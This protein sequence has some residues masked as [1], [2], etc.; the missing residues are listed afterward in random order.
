[1][2]C[3]PE[4]P[5]PNLLLFVADTLRADALRCYG[6]AA[7]TPNICGLAERGVLFTAAQANAP[8]TSPSAVSL[9][10]GSYPTAYAN[11]ASAGGGVS[12]FWVSDEE[13]LLGDALRARG[14]DVRFG[15]S[16]PLVAQTNALQGF[17]PLPEPTRPVDP[18]L[19]GIGKAGRYLRAHDGTPFFLLEWVM[20][21]HAPYEARGVLERIEVDRSR[22]PRPLEF[23]TRL[24]HQLPLSMR[25]YAPGMSDYELEV[26]RRL[27]RAEVE[28]IDAKFGNLARALDAA[29]LRESTYV[30]FTSDHGEGFGEHGT[31]LHGVSFHDELTRVPLIVAG[32]GIAP[33]RRVDAPVSLVDLMPTLRDLLGVDCLREPQGRSLADRL[34]GERAGAPEGH[35]HY[36]SSPTDLSRGI[37]ALVEG[38]YKLIAKLDGSVELYDLGDDPGERRDLA[39]QRSAVVSRMRAELAAIRSEKDARRRRNFARQT[40]AERLEVEARTRSGLRELGYIE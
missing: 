27:Y 25:D 5:R 26:L 4:A 34:R 8:W 14:Y 19:A 33:G 21:A 20:D 32:P 17:E 31:F 18:A 24:G 9:F 38:E 36:L 10:T 7:E 35:A 37:D 30:V 6:G 13:V 29:G 23:Y 39:S 15:S 3:R 1:V 11:L 28:A 12:S 22:L 2:Q 16:S 40:E